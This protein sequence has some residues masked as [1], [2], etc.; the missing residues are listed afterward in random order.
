MNVIET[1][2]QYWGEKEKPGNAGF[3]NEKLQAIMTKAGHKKG[4]AWC[5]YFAEAVFC[6]AMPDR[7]EELRALFSAST[8]KTFEN[9]RKAN[10]I[11]SKIPVMYSLVI[12][13]RYVNGIAQWQGHAGIVCSVQDELNFKSIEGNTNSDGS[14]E[15]D[16]IQIKNRSTAIKKT[17]LN[18]M[19]FVIIQP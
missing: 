8:V 6:E 18:I 1:A 16:S 7:E 17:G 10:F 9:F 13:R 5:A 11:I 14:R 2:L 12:W 19:G 4:E 3:Y 15:G